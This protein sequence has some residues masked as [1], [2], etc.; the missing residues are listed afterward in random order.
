M[1]LSKTRCHFT[2]VSLITLNQLLIFYF[3][4]KNKIY[5]FMQYRNKYEK[6][7][8]KNIDSINRILNFSI[9]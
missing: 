9:S 7:S 4:D 2:Y 5:N 1:N 8:N 6:N 3:F